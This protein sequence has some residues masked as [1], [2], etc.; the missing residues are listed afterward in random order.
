MDITTLPTQVEIPSYSIESLLQKA[1]VHG[2]QKIYSKI[3]GIVRVKGTVTKIN[4][5]THTTYLTLKDREFNI[6][7]KCDSKQQVYEN[8]PIVVEG[9]LLLKP[10]T[11]F[12]GL[13]CYIDG[14]IVG[15]WEL[16]NKPMNSEYSGLKKTRFLSLE[17]LLAEEDP[18]S[19]LLLGTEIGISDVTSQLNSQ[20]ANSINRFVI[21]VGRADSLLDDI[22]EAC[23]QNFRAFV[24]VRGGDDNTMEIWNDPNIV[25]FLLSYSLPFYTALGHSHS[26]TLA[27]QYA[28]GSYY[29]PT[30]F[31]AALNSVL[32]RKKK[33]NQIESEYSR[34]KQ[35]N[36]LLTNA[37]L[38]TPKDSKPRGV[39]MIAIF[40]A[41]T[42]LLYF[43]FKAIG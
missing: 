1:G 24:I 26:R 19:I 33:L 3:D 42:V 9:M 22:K 4:R 21:R 14:N 40:S 36:V 31:G 37:A 15:S 2:Q 30:A 6:S 11:F 20:V 29:T 38:Y 39:K 13:E 41:Y 8:A 18:S 35:E 32:S 28:D 12:T 17:D 23:P 25:S 27:D 10:S 7:V 16:T 5:Y 34:L 43:L